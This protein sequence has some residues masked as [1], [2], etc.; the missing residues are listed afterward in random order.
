L[1]IIKANNLKTNNALDPLLVQL[2][3]DKDLVQNKIL[4]IENFANNLNEFEKVI[5][6]ILDILLQKGIKLYNYPSKCSSEQFS[7][8]IHITRN[9]N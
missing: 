6:N 1:I 2:I 9:G 4:E 5:I 3:G 8:Y 7:D